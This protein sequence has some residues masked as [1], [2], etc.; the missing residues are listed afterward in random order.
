MNR[1]ILKYLKKYLYYFDSKYLKNIHI[2]L[3]MILKFTL[4]LQII[5][6]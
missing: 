3:T 5:T 2:I 6:Y 1:F 4:T